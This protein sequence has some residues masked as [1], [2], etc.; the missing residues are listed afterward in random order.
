MPNHNNIMQPQ[1]ERAIEVLHI[2]D[3]LIKRERISYT[4]Y[5][6]LKKFIDD[7]LDQLHFLLGRS[8]DE[9]EKRLEREKHT[10]F[11]H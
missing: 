3:D 4:L 11:T 7:R 6:E 10:A 1:I 5:E 9:V 8:W 2:A